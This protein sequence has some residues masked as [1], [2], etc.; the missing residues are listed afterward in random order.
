[1]ACPESPEFFFLPVKTQKQLYAV[2]H[3][4]HRFLKQH[5]IVHWAC[6]GT[7][8]GVVRHKGLIPWDD[9]VDFGIPLAQR[10][11][12]MAIPEKEWEAANLALGKHWLG[13]KIYFKD[14]DAIPNTGKWT[15]KYP[16]VD[17]F[18]W[19]KHGDKWR[20]AR[21]EKALWHVTASDY[22]PNEYFTDDELF[23]L[24]T[25][26]FDFPGCHGTLPI[27]AKSRAYVD[28]VYRGWHSV[29]STGTWNHRK[30]AP[31]KPCKYSMSEVKKVEETYFDKHKRP[32]C[33]SYLASPKIGYYMINCDVHTV[34][35]KKFMAQKGA[36]PFKKMPCVYYKDVGMDVFCDF[37]KDKVD[38]NRKIVSSHYKFKP[39]EVAI[40][41]SHYKLWSLFLKSNNEYCVVVEDDTVLNPSFE[42]CVNEV[43]VPLEGTFDVLFF[44]HGLWKG[45]F[46][47]PN[48]SV[49]SDP[50]ISLQD[51]IQTSCAKEP[52]K[53]FSIG[54]PYTAGGVAYLITRSYAAH[55][56]RHFFPI[57]WPV[58]DYMGSNKVKRKGSSHRHLFLETTEQKN[59]DIIASALVSTGVEVSTVDRG[60]DRLRHQC[61]HKVHG[62]KSRGGKGKAFI[63][64]LS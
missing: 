39:A 32:S 44:W 50:A 37:L 61:K 34:R 21:G 22:W 40:S 4:T 3:Q 36:R 63:E 59:N 27:P 48:F 35:F 64:R 42:N 46:E 10:H 29:A 51:T 9:D 47:I 6:E 54:R 13:F 24:T 2:A 7:L 41:L 26:V 5:G 8:L 53:V 43:L 20:Y 11:K 57:V 19:E 52:V 1:M 62:G 15:Y 38:G 28:R 23:P 17:L 12:L 45:K 30:E 60:E 14:G 58:D 33:D 55:L 49:K 16:F 18:V 25:G 56:C 31:A